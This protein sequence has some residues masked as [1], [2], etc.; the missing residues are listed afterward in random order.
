MKK[1]NAIIVLLSFVLGVMIS[2]QVKGFNPSYTFVTLKSVKEM[3]SKLETEKIEIENL[4]KLVSEKRYMLELYESEI[5]E[6]GSVVGL[7]STELS[8]VKMLSGFE[9][10][11][12]PGII[13]KLKDSE[14]ELIDG[15]NANDV[16]IHDADVI[17]VVN[18]LK[19]AGAEA[20]SINGERIIFNSE[21]KCAGATITINSSTYGQ[22][23]V[24]RAIGDRTLLEAAVRSPG[25]Y[26]YAL[27]EIFD[28]DVETFV[29]DEMKINGYNKSVKFKYAKKE[30]E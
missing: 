22:P 2:I 13:V 15:E 5:A 6:K 9:D 24:I 21:I 29:V 10:V 26:V 20:I 27:K 23:F 7:V 28:F 25:S 4:K 17:T 12:G 1:K 18:S 30:G 14:R 19:E 11:K 3:E 8:D 16:V